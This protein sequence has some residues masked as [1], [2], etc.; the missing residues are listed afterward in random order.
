M[1]DPWAT[2]AWSA[3]DTQPSI[4]SLDPPPGPPASDPWSVPAASGPSTPPS[5]QASK[6]PT[7]PLK[8]SHNDLGWEEQA[9]WGA[10]NSPVL[11]PIPTLPQSPVKLKDGE[12]DVW[13]DDPVPLPGSPGIPS[14]SAVDIA[15]NVEISAT[16][17]T[18]TTPTFASPSRSILASSPLSPHRAGLPASSSHASL[19]EA[20]IG[21]FGGF[22]SPTKAASPLSG[23]PKSPSFGDDF[24]GFSGFAASSPDDPW[25]PKLETSATKEDDG[26]G[27][28]D[29]EEPSQSTPGATHIGVKTPKSDASD[30]GWGGATEMGPKS[31]VKGKEEDEWEEAQRRIRVTEERAPREKIDD[32]T[33]QWIKLAEANMTEAVDLTKMTGAEELQ[34]EQVINKV[35]EDASERIRSLSTIPPDINTYPPVL[36]SLVTH[37]RYAYALQRPN[38]DPESSLLHSATRAARR[39]RRIDPISLSLSTGEASWTTRSRLGEPEQDSEAVAG[40]AGDGKS[41][42]AFWGKRPTAER[43]LTTGGGGALEVKPMTPTSTGS[44]VEKPRPSTDSKPPSLPA[45]RAASIAGPSSRPVSPAPPAPPAPP[46]V[47]EQAVQGP[48]AVSRFFGRLSR[49]SSS[50]PNSPTTPHAPAGSVDAKD[51]ELSADDFSFLSEV[52]SMSA[53]PPGKGVADLLSMEPGAN[54]PIKSLENLLNSK[55]APLPKPLA[56]PPSGPS[57]PAYGGGERE[58]KP[59]GKFVAKMKAP[60]PSDIDLLGGLDFA[61]PTI[62]TVSPT[63]TGPTQKTGGAWDDFESF[64]TSPTSGSMPAPMQPSRPT[65]PAIVN[66]SRSPPPIIAPT[67]HSAVGM[68]FAALALQPPMAP[69]GISPAPSVSPEPPLYH[70]VKTTTGLQGFGK[71]G[72]PRDEKPGG[73]LSPS[74]IVPAS[75]PATFAFYGGMVTPAAAAG[76]EAS[77]SPEPQ[78]YVNLSTDLDLEGFGKEGTPRVLTPMGVSPATSPAPARMPQVMPGG[79]MAF[80]TAPPVPRAA[81]SPTPAAYGMVSGGDDFGDFGSATPSRK[82]TPAGLEDFDDFGDFTSSSPPASTPPFKPKASHPIFSSPSRPVVTLPTPKNSPPKPHHDHTPALK[83]MTRSNSVKG[84]MWPAP[85]SPVPQALEPPPKT[86]GTEAFPFLAPPP[87]GVKKSKGDLMGDLG[88]A[89]NGG[90]LGALGPAPVTTQPSLTASKPTG[91]NNGQ[92]GGGLS[93]QDLSFFDSL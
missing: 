92:S 52:P 64:M 58:R 30:E 85:P 90:S 62:S 43:K 73:M 72:T 13:G 19:S 6:L 75:D 10:D 37:E 3:P 57:A 17:V 60:Q 79:A 71:V 83:L 39:P 16:P 14:Q 35:F 78:A 61:S 69:T 31:P 48:S 41:K 7:S 5:P 23:I 15:M 32:M 22:E 49:R 68:P 8:E 81:M 59:S 2:P 28:S 26:W 70:S 47:N 24:G 86:A 67:A 89:T 36:S 87:G 77:I 38:P 45:S 53:P 42:W 91:V 20:V 93:A 65:T 12:G 66:P 54:E 84:K 80:N 82:A 9:S 76:M 88:E 21:G 29:W 63:S 44:G 4:P 56:P 33:N 25:G 27:G 11:A 40:D 46:T 74:A 34:Y 18:S 1:D 51:L 55:E 50:Q